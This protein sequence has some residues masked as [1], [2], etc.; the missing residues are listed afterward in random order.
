MPQVRLNVTPFASVELL[1]EYLGTDIPDG[2]LIAGVALK[3]AT[4]A[5]QKYCD[6]TLA[7]ISEDTVTLDG[8]GSDTLLLPD[9]PVTDI[10]QVILDIDRGDSAVELLG[11]ENG[12]SSQFDWNDEGLLFRRSGG[13]VT[14][15]SPFSLTYGKWPLRRRSVQVTYSHGYQVGGLQSSRV[16]GK[17]IGEVINV[18]GFSSTA[19]DT[20]V[21]VVDETDDP[22]VL[23]D[24]TPSGDSGFTLAVDTTADTLLVTFLA[25]NKVPAD[26]Q[27]VCVAMAARSYVQDG[28]TQESMGSYSISYGGQPASLTADERLILDRY[29]DRRR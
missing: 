20:L 11:P 22:D 15:G 17:D 9:V 13:F 4:N 19:G 29:R 6:Q 26:I 8:S 14:M 23:L 28:A 18:N 24:F 10:S 12:A 16:L 27:L 2:S 1:A 7:Y 25:S 5:I 21:T 3:A